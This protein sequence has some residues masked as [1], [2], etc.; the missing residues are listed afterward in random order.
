MKKYFYSNGTEK[1]GPFSFD[2]LKTE[3]ITQETLIWFEGLED[4]TVAYEIEELNEIFELIPP[5]VIENEFK[6]VNN[7]F[8]EKMSK[9][10]DDELKLIVTK[11]REDYII[12]ALDAAEF[13]LKNRGL[14]DDGLEML[15]KE[16][17]T[18]MKMK[19]VRQNKPRMFKNPFSFEGRIRRLEYWL[20]FLIWYVY[21]VLVVVLAAMLN[22]PEY[23]F[24]F[25][26][27]GLIFLWAQGSKRCHDLG[28]S[29][30]Y[31][32]IPFYGLWML[33]V[34]GEQTLS[35]KYGINPKN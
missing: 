18:K 34:N 26:L 13:E 6:I 8:H 24:L 20:S 15:I 23:L 30:W 3:N 9:L 35:N 12:E 33:F 4:W 32:I 28:N 27:P 11:K 16:K 10:S 7:E 1:Q 22:L 19:I 14:F 25:Y 2:E 17:D 29:G 31:Q 5:P 21:I